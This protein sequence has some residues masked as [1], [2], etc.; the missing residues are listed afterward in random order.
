MYV[1]TRGDVI[2]LDFTPQAGSEMAGRHAAVVLTPHAYAVATGLALVVPLTTK[3]KGGS[4]EVA[5]LGAA[6]AKGVVLANELRSIDFAARNADLF[7]RCPDAVFERILDI[8]FALLRA[9]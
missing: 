8:A 5:M 6:K 4:F 1:P 2:W 9:E 7:D 3:A